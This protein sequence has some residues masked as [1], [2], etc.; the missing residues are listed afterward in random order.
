LERGG[1]A[2][3]VPFFGLLREIA[4]EVRP[5]GHGTPE[6][7]VVRELFGAIEFLVDEHLADV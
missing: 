2:G 4:L 3:D 7:P 5:I 6:L 1:R